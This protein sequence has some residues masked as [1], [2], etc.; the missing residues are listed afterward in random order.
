M[1]SGVVYRASSGGKIKK[2]D[3]LNIYTTGLVFENSRNGGEIIGFFGQ[4]LNGEEYVHV[5]TITSGT[6]LFR[7][8]QKIQNA[9][10]YIPHGCKI[11]ID[12]ATTVYSWTDQLKLSGFQGVERS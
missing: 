9:G 1:A 5:L 12:L 4:A 8:N 2:M 11:Q 6:S 7:A 10:P 3:L